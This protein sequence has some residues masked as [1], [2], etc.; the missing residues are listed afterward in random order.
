MDWKI[1]FIILSHYRLHEVLGAELAQDRN[2]NKHDLQRL[3]YL[4]AV[5]K[6]SLRLYPPAPRIA[7]YLNV[8]VKL[9]KFY[10][11]D[12]KIRHVYH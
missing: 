6:E 11:D 10:Y 9:S 12:Y 4:E 7:R 1:S 3:V 8:D 5:I 2:L